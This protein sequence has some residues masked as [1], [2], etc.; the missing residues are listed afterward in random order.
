MK[1]LEINKPLI[2]S[3]RS[4]SEKATTIKFKGDIVLSAV[5]TLFSLGL[6]ISVALIIY[7]IKWECNLLKYP[8]SLKDLSINANF[9]N[10]SNNKL[11]LGVQAKHTWIV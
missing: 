4:L 3:L 1:Y 5:I 11:L 9:T 6:I 10:F 2:K 8:L 7:V